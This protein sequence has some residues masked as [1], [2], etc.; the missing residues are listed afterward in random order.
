MLVTGGTGF[1]GSHLV[2]TLVRRGWRVRLLLRETS[3]LRWLEGQPIEY[4]YGDVRDKAS[5]AGACVGVRGVFHFGGVTRA[6]TA[7]EFAAVERTGD[8]STSP[9]PGR[10]R[11]PGRVLRLLQQ[12]GRGRPRNSGGARSVAGPDRGGSAHAGHPL[13]SQQARRRDRAARGRGRAHP[14]PLRDP[15]AARRLRT[16]RRGS[17]RPLS[18]DP[19]R[20]PADARGRSSRASASSTSRT[21]STPR[22]R[23]WMSEARGTYYVSDGDEYSWSEVGELAAQLMAAQ[24]RTVRVSRFAAKLAAS[25]CETWGDHHPQPRGVQPGQ[26]R[27]ALAGALGVPAGEGPPGVGIRSALPSGARTGRDPELV[28]SE[29]VVVT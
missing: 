4:A 16:A 26:G 19:A 5:L 23:P 17:D 24:V 13:R 28:S 6:F 9:R 7:S 21:W 2:E 10:A 3:S 8:P 25:L 20:N 1:V 14:V 11:R 15:A 27:G 29:P 22:S 12:H 18:R